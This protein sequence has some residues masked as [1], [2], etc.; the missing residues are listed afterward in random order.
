[1]EV[2]PA[3]AQHDVSATCQGSHRHI[4][5]DLPEGGVGVHEERSFVVVPICLHAVMGLDLPLI[6]VDPR[7]SIHR[8]VH[9][10]GATEDQRSLPGFFQRSSS[11][12]RGAFLDNAVSKTY[13]IGEV[14]LQ[15]RVRVDEHLIR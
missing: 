14:V 12:Y 13:C 2:G 4:P 6:Q 10:T 8:D 7:T 15:Y 1:M 3:V 11:R 5:F 9:L